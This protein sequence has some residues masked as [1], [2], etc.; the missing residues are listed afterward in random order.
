[1]IYLF[2]LSEVFDGVSDVCNILCVGMS[3]RV[4]D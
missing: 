1:M 4:M 2:I 3:V